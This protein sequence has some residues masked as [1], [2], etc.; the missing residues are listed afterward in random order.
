M[1]GK[2]LDYP[3][4]TS[5][6]YDVMFRISLIDDP[7]RR[8]NSGEELLLKQLEALDHEEAIKIYRQYIRCEK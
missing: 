1:S 2:L 5:Q 6:F 3:L 7:E 8:H 4:N